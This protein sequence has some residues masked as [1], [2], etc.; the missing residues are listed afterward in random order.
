MLWILTIDVGKD[1]GKDVSMYEDAEITLRLDV[2]QVFEYFPTLNQTTF[3]DRFGINRSLLNQYIK[4]H[5]RPSEKQSYKILQ[6]IRTLGI[7]VYIGNSFLISKQVL[8][9]KQLPCLTWMS[10]T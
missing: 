10:R 3:A 6:G 9:S 2:A 8:A 4:G 7:G 5:R 1:I